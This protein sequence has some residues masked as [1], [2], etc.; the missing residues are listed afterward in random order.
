MIYKL[1]VENFMSL[2]HVSLELEPLTVFIGPNGSGKSA[3]FKAL[4]LLSK[5][6][7]GTPVRGTKGELVLESGI[8]L[9]D[10]VWNGDSGCQSGFASGLTGIEMANLTTL[11]S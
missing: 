9:D 7:N 3:I 1:E 2:K 5:L 10:L 8:T 11:L 4:V 6:L